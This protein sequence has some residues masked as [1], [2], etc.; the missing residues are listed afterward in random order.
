MVHT[1]DINCRN[2]GAPVPKIQVCDHCGTYHSN[3]YMNKQKLDFKLASGYD[4]HVMSE[5]GIQINNPGHWIERI[6]KIAT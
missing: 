3:A 4:F 1:L 5:A 6:I 2:C